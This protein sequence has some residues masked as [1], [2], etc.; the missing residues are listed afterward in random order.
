MLDC[1]CRRRQ[2]EF[3]QIYHESA[4]LG[5]LTLQSDNRMKFHEQPVAFIPFSTYNLGRRPP[6]SLCIRYS[7]PDR[8]NGESQKVTPLPPRNTVLLC[9]GVRGR[10]QQF[11]LTST[12]IAAGVA[13]N[14]LSA[15]PHGRLVRTSFDPRKCQLQAVDQGSKRGGV[16]TGAGVERGRG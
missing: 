14:L 9:H 13:Q 7:P 1:H 4:C 5:F 10:N 3:M 2:R 8:K 15:P 6:Q 12:D 11:M 16:E